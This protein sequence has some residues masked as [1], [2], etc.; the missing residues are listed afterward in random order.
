MNNKITKSY[1]VQ[2][3]LGLKEGYDGIEHTIDEVYDI[4]QKYVNTIKYCV[5]V[6]PT[7][8]IYVNGNENGVIIGLINYPRFPNTQK[9]IREISFNLS[10]IFLNQFKQYRI[11]VTTPNKT[12]LI[13]N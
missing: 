3:W 7:K 5:T 8:F 10:D 1:N 2:I 11:S 13:E 9:K 12:Y 4:C 6:T